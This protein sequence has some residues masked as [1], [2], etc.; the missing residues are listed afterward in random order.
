MVGRLLLRGM[1]VGLVAALLAFGVAKIYGEPQV[2]QAIAFETASEAAPAAMTMADGKMDMSANGTMHMTTHEA[3]NPEIFSRATQSGL[4]LF[5][6]LMIYGAAFG[7]LFALVFAFAYG[8]MGNL[9]PRG[10]SAVLALLVF[11]AVIVVPGL[12]YPANPPAVGDPETIALR[13]LLYFGMLAM[14]VAGMGLAVWLAG[15]LRAQHGVWNA[16]ILAGLAYG[17]GLT[18]VSLLMPGIDE[19]P[20]GFS[21]SLLWQFRIAAWAI[22]AVLWAGIGLGFGLAAEQLLMRR[23]GALDPG[24]RAA[25]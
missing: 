1:I 22:Q 14:S 11:V 16:A 5:T 17:A 24:L 20:P 23:T 9:G 25:R 19:V 10:T 18:V 12:K 3:A 8:R 6:G 13:T 15:Q 2:D 4:G 21:A 7:G